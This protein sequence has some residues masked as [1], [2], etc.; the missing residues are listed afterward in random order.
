MGPY[1]QGTSHHLTKFSQPN[2]LD[3]AAVDRRVVK[4]TF[5]QSVFTRYLMIRRLPIFKSR[6]V[7]LKKRVFLQI[8]F[9][10]RPSKFFP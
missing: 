3:Q 7:I 9:E 2:F 4:K 5:A 10:Q 8:S 6:D 1:P